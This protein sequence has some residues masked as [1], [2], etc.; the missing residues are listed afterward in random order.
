MSSYVT[1]PH[2]H[3]HHGCCSGSRRLQAPAPPARPRLV[4]AAAA[5]HV[6]LPPRRA[7]ASRAMS[8]EAPL[9]VAPAAAEEEMAAVVDEMAE[10]A[11]VWC[12]VHGLVVGDRA[13]PRSG[14]IPGVGLVHAPFALLPTRFPASFWKQARELAPIFNDLVDRVSLDGEFLQDSLSRTRQVD[15]FTSRLLDIHAKM[16]EVNKE[17]DI[18]LGLH[19]SDYMLDSGTNSLL[20]I[21]LNTI[22]S[23]FPGLS[24]L[25]SELHRTLLNRHGKVLGLDSKRIPQNWAATQFAE[26]LSMAWTEFNNKSAV[27]MMVVQPEERNMYDQYW[28]INHLKESHGVKTIRKTLAQVEAEGQVL[29]DGTLVVDGQTVSVVY[30]RAGYSPNDYPSE[31]EW[32]A[33]LLMEQSSAIKCPSI[34]YH[35][36]GTK[37]IQ[38][39]LAKPNILERFLNN[40]EDIAKLRKCFAG[41]WSLDN[42]EIVKT[43]IEK[44]DLFVLKPQ[45]EGGGNN[46]YGYDLRETLVRLQKEQGEALAAYILMQRIFPRASLTHLVQGG[47]CFEDLTISE[48]GIFGAYLRNKDKVVLNN[49][50]GYLMRTKVSSSNEGGVAAGFAVLDSILLTDEW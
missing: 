32:R 22:S 4:V 29:P 11:A 36:V 49:Q 15:D 2:H 13:E 31:A 28:L 14:T 45:R 43:A 21:E 27:I 25:V 38:Q 19:R 40:K 16:M 9:G 50:C 6:A 24:S 20:Q 23:S 5:R 37:K 44:P 8:A 42:E 41:L 47:V 46:I 34:S 12:A 30:F 3:H 48:L 1:T 39:E 10:E 17:E 26:A 33:R 35:L 18:R 7:V